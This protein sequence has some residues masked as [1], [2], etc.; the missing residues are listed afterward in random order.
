MDVLLDVWT[1]ELVVVS[2]E[3]RLVLL[4][5]FRNILLVWC[6]S[7]WHFSELLSTHLVDVSIQI[8]ELIMHVGLGRILDHQLAGVSG[9]AHCRA[10]NTMLLAG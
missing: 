3:T 5:K 9:D 7:L 8:A 10:A 1:R 6:D 2:A 4:K